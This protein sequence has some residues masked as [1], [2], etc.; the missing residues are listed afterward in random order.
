MINPKEDKFQ[1]IIGENNQMSKTQIE[2]CNFIAYGIGNATVQSRAGSGKSKTIELMCAAINPRKKILIISHNNHIAK[3]LQKKLKDKENI[4]VCTYHS[5]GF[6][7]LKTK[8]KNT[9]IFKPT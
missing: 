4:D 2:L 8:F 3:H 1:K 5:L 6:K 9:V 7:I